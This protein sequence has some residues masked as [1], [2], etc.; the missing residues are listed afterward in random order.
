MTLYIAGPCIIFHLEVHE[1]TTSSAL[2]TDFVQGRCM[3]WEY[4]RSIACNLSFRG[5]ILFPDKH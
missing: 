2:K 4:N 1:Q 3:L 5:K